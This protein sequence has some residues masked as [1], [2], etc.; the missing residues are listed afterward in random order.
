MNTDHVTTP[1]TD[2]ADSST[3]RDQ[4]TIAEL[5]CDLTVVSHRVRDLALGARARDRPPRRSAAQHRRRLDSLHA[6]H[7]TRAT[8]GGPSAL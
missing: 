4:R 6:E 1:A 8:A 7:R 3:V 5:T 2:D